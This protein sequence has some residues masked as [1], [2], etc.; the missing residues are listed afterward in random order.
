MHAGEYNQIVKLLRKESIENDYTQTI[1]WKEYRSTR[2]NVKHVQGNREE[3][4]SEIFYTDLI[5]VTIRYYHCQDIDDE[6]HIS[7]QGR[8]YRITNIFRD[9]ITTAR[10]IKITA[11]LINT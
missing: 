6:D 10:E 3:Q 1:V 4:N 2:A 7:W 8:E 5:E 9:S 11:E